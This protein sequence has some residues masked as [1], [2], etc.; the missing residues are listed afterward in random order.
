MTGNSISYEDALATFDSDGNGTFSASEMDSFMKASGPSPPPMDGSFALQGSENDTILSLLNQLN[1]SQ[2][3]SPEESFAQID[4]NG[5][6]GID[7]TE[8]QSMMEGVSE[9][10]D[11]DFSASDAI[12]EYKING[13]GT[14]DQKEMDAFIQ[15]NRP[16]FQA[17]Q[18]VSAYA[19]NTLDTLSQLISS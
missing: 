1:M 6:G 2:P 17:Q 19:S 12:A 7:A 14:L 15:N 18:T 10:S 13:D 3:P 11:S 5:E 9:S 8:L 16:S 4:S